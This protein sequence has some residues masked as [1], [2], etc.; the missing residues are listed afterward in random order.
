MNDP[1][2]NQLEVIVER[3]VR[4]VR[5]SS[6]RKQTMREEMLAHVSSVYEDEVTRLGQEGAP[7]RL[8]QVERAGQHL[9][10]PGPALVRLHVL[11]SMPY[12]DSPRSPSAR[13][14]S[15][16]GRSPLRHNATRWETR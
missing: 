6:F 3:V 14:R 9:G 16:R 7:L 11:S 10:D 8:R 2:L 12:P 13:R 1:V 15:S 4:P 5:A